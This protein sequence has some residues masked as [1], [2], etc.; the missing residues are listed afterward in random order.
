M[1]RISRTL[2]L[3]RSSWEVLKADKEL[4]I[5]PVLSAIAT[6][7]VAASFIAPIILRGDATDLESPG[8]FEIAMMFAAYVVLAFITTFFNAAL[9][10]A[11]SNTLRL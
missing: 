10:H 9:V 4:L 5:L 6:L 3:A 8:G 2:H 1:S 11:A 7:V